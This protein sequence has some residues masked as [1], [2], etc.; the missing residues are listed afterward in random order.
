MI[1]AAAS[2]VG[3]T[4]FWYALAPGGEGIVLGGVSIAV[5]CA[6]GLRLT[7]AD[8]ES[9]PLAR[10]PWLIA[11]FFARLP[12]AMSESAR[13]LRAALAADVTLK[14]ELLRIRAR[15]SDGFS[16][17]TFANALTS[18]AAAIVVETDA[19]GLFAHLM[20]EDALDAR[21]LAAL[22]TGA[23]AAAGGRDAQ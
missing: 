3:L 7:Q 2:L 19:E 10:A 9:A 18:A 13:V 11:F 21:A 5:A 4:A 12:A 14:P 22:E 8:R 17:A 1:Y 23:N 20:Q 6:L 15:T 16:R